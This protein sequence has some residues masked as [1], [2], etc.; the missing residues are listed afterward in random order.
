MAPTKARKERNRAAKEQRAQGFLNLCA[1]LA[2]DKEFLTL[3]S[4]CIDSVTLNVY[5]FA[6]AQLTDYKENV[7]STNAF[8]KV[9]TLLG[10]Y[11]CHELSTSIQNLHESFQAHS[12]K[13]KSSRLRTHC[14]KNRTVKRIGFQNPFNTSTNSLHSITLSK[15]STPYPTPKAYVFER[16]ESILDSLKVK[17]TSCGKC[18]LSIPI[19]E[20]KLQYTLSAPE[21]AIIEIVKFLPTSLSLL[22]EILQR[23]IT[24]SS[25]LGLLISS[26]I[27][28][29]EEHYLNGM[30]QENWQE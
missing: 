20:S 11:S 22:F 3:L 29:I 15:L 9:K 13:S 28:S 24:I 25:N 8:T 19:D 5:V 7:V 2:E 21:S 6:K 4:E 26:R 18:D 1:I 27:P 17:D 14:R 12:F 30:G 10:S 16:S 23:I